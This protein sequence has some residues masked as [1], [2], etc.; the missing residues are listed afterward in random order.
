MSF[1][2]RQILRL[3]GGTCSA[4]AMPNLARRAYAAADSFE[5][6]HASLDTYRVPEWFRDAKFGIWAHWGPQSAIEDGDWY[7]RNMYIQGSDQYQYQLTNYGHPSKVGYKDLV[8]IWHASKWDPDHLMR[9]YKKAGAKYFVSMGVHHDNFDLWDSKYTRWNAVKMGPK[10]DV[11]GMW[12][13]A[14]KKHGL[15]FGVSEHLWISYKWF[16]VSHGADKTGPLAGVAYDGR[17]PQFADLYHDADCERFIDRLDWNDND[18]PESWKKHY[19]NR[20]TDLIDK[21]QPDLLYTDGHLPFEEYGMRMVSHLYNVSAQLHGG[22]TEAV[23]T[24]KDSL[25]CAIGTCVLDHERGVAEGISE[26]PWQTDTCIGQW[27]YKKGQIYKTPKKVIDLLVDIVSKNGNLLLNFPLPN[28]GELDPAEMRTLEGVTKWMEANSEGI[29]GTR[30][31]KIYGEG[32][33]TQQKIA[34][35]NF[36]EDKQKDLTGEDIRYT[37]KGDTVFAFIM[38]KPEIAEVN[39]L[40]LWSQQDPGKIR[41]VQILGSGGD[42]KWIQDNASLRVKSPAELPSDIGF[43]LKVDFA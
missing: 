6:T 34:T 15:R 7:A 35:G 27:H 22:N 17:D 24:S 10:K 31:W 8:N 32:P 40:G 11:V 13:E 21:Y 9:L 41:R 23:Y 26:H 2:R 43:T 4:L 14:A 25:D 19:L 29:Y 42:V 37:K 5:P 38:G 39:A 20:M 16:A 36:N 1:S 30:P 18:I 3:M 28:S 12:K 33:S